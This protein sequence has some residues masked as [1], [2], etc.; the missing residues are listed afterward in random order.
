MRLTGQA[1]A[2][3]PSVRSDGRSLTRDDP[4]L[5]A[6]AGP[7]VSGRWRPPTR[8]E[9]CVISQLT[10]TPTRAAGSL[11]SARHAEAPEPPAVSAARWRQPGEAAAPAARADAWTSSCSPEPRHRRSGTREKDAAASARF[12][13]EAQHSQL[14]QAERISTTASLVFKPSGTGSAAFRRAPAR[15]ASRCRAAVRS[16]PAT[17]Q[18]ANS[19]VVQPG[20]PCAAASRGPIPERRPAGRCPGCPGLP[21]G[22]WASCR[23]VAATIRH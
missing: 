15:R 2:G 12:Q 19:C 14:D 6:R 5:E 3:Q 8:G 17:S 11:P 21:R 1:A 9:W 22:C 23:A 20:A 16:Q 7:G 13:T 4:L 18:W 10:A